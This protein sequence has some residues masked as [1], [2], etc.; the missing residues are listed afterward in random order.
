MAL[1][2]E[3]KKL[4]LDKKNFR[5][6]RQYKENGLK[7]QI[8]EKCWK[9]EIM[10]ILDTWIVTCG[11]NGNDGGDSRGLKASK[12]ELPV[13]RRSLVGHTAPAPPST[14]TKFSWPA[15]KGELP[16]CR[17][18]LAG[19]TAPAPPSMDTHWSWPTSSPKL[20]LPGCGGRIIK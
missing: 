19:Y 5:A 16:V 3:R 8:L 2:R 13:C 15:G 7:K 9:I 20:G 4:N 12:G 11:Y 17:R 6:A 10:D 14:D 18:S 1:Q